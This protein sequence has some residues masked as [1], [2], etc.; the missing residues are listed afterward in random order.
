MSSLST[1]PKGDSAWLLRKAIERIM[2]Q[3]SVLETNIGSSTTGNSADTQIIFNDNGTLRGD[4]G[5]VY[6]KATDLLSFGA[7]LCYGLL[8]SASATITG[9]LTVDTNVLKVDSAN[10]RVGIGTASPSTA[11][12][13]ATA[14]T[15]TR[16]RI[17]S[18][19]VVAT[20]YFRSGTGLWLVGSDSTNAFKIARGSNFGGSADYF[21]I[22]SAD[23]A[24]TWYD[25]AG[26]TRMT[27]NATGLGVGV[28]PSVWV[29]TYKALQASTYAS[30]A[31][32]SDDKLTAVSNNFYN[33]GTAKF[34]GN[35]YAAS[36]SQY[37]GA[38]R[39][40]TSTASNSS[41]AGAALTFTQAMTLDA[42]G[43]LLVGTTSAGGN[44]LNV[45]TA[46]GDCLTL[47]KS[48]A[49]NVNLAIDYVSSYGNHTIRKSG[50]AVWDFGVINDATATPAF[51]VS[52]ASAVG[53]QLVSGAT[54]WT[55]LSD[56]TVKDIIEPITNA[57]TKV[58]SLRSVIGKF[59]TDSE[60]T[61]RSFLIAQD[62]KS[63]LPEAVDVVGENNEL[64]LRY[65][66]VIPLLVAAIQ[67]LS[68]EVNALKNA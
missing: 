6:N 7:G 51:K 48:Q 4:T 13:V 21:A 54:S 63:V 68:A 47:I 45:Q 55:T 37:Q 2:Q 22:A 40:Q 36:Y 15:N 28:T 66:E 29:S 10:N 53:V 33:D 14:S 34:V 60:G 59:K 25:A 27:L 16:F 17:N 26:G 41:G 19:E 52:N 62:V 42:S 30:F 49:A 23:A 50:T 43:N 46:S 44:R 56:E 12:E 20:E 18:T 3:V 24:A 8:T 64:G 11:L 39:W 65:T 38:H 35:G 58:G 67:E 57:I 9:D 61:R 1:L 31:G 5:L 32:N